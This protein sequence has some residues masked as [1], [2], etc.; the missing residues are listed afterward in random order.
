MEK[1]HKR[2]VTVLFALLAVASIASANYHA[3][4]Y[5]EELTC[6]GE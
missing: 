2:I 1:N 4:P 6:R 5:E 3:N